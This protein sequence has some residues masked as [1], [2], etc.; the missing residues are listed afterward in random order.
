MEL[1]GVIAADADDSFE[2]GPGVSLIVR[3]VGSVSGYALTIT[4]VGSLLIAFFVGRW[5]GVIVCGQVPLIV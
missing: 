3:V 1:P 2:F 5:L 4:S